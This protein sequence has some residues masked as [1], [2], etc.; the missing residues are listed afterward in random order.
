MLLK[1]EQ[2]PAHLERVLHPVY[3]LHGDEPLLVLEAADAIRQKAR[4]EG[5]DE[6]E[7]LTVLSGFD[8]GQLAAAG[9]NLSLFGGRKLIDLRIPNG[10][11]GRD[12]SQALQAYCQQLSS[13]NLLLVSLPELD[14]KD[15]KAA[16]LTALGEVGVVVKLTALPLAELPG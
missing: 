8:W 6:R 3:V 12:G 10:K 16:W 13:D 5:F 2:L 14:W 4:Q 15:E 9:C 11:P 7:V 1:G